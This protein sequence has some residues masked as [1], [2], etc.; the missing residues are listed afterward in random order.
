[1]GYCRHVA[2]CRNA[3]AALVRSGSVHGSGTGNAGSSCENHMGFR[4]STGGLSLPRGHRAATERLAHQMV[5][6]LPMAVVCHRVRPARPH[7]VSVGTLHAPQECGLPVERPGPGRTARSNHDSA[8]TVEAR[9]RVAF[10]RPSCGDHHPAAGPARAGRG[11]LISGCT[12][13]MSPP[14]GARP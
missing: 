8:P 12:A 1:M 14:G 3:R 10:P 13:H 4:A 7:D 9:L 2:Y 5:L 6:S 11:G